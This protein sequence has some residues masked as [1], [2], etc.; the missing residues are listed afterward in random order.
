MVKSPT[1]PMGVFCSAAS[2]Q[3][4][5]L[6]AHQTHEQWNGNVLSVEKSGQTFSGCGKQ[7]E[8]LSFCAVLV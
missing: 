4:K 1:P 8:I 7:L 2:D 3:K 5:L 6:C